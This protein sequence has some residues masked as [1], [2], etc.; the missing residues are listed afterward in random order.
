MRSLLSILT[1][2]AFAAM[3]LMGMTPEARRSYLQFEQRAESGDAEAMYRLGTILERGWDS[4][5]PDT[6][7]ALKM[8]RA[9]A[10]AGFPP[11]MNYMGYLYGEGFGDPAVTGI[12]ADR[13]SAEMWLR[14]SADAGDPRAM[15]NLAYLLLNYADSTAKKCD[16]TEVFHRRDS[17]AAIYLERASALGA[18]TASS[19][20]GD[21]YREGRGVAVDT[22]R[23]VALYESAMRSGLRDAEMRL[24]SMMGRKWERL[25]RDSAFNLGLGYYSTFAPTAGTILI[26]QCALLP[27]I[28]VD[29]LST[30]TVC[31][32]LSLAARAMTLT[33]D[34]YSRGYGRRYNHDK[35]MEWYA[36]GALGGDPSA[37]FIIAETLEVFPD[38]LKDMWDELA[39]YADEIGK[40]EQARHT[41]AT[42]SGRC[43]TGVL[44]LDDLKD[45]ELLKRLAARK[46]VN[47]AVSANRALFA[48]S[49]H[50]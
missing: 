2:V 22:L 37:M 19:M 1:G 4:I 44:T 13:D 26:E 5:A 17:L 41:F 20:L 10:E 6:L 7:R 18:P 40:I 27:G 16:E 36:K 11:A 32:S 39:N 50:R 24:I 14:R 33:G 12:R 48:T 28:P 45:V 25:D 9:S 35:S 38:A 23:A 46:G 42:G 3:T 15:S 43:G 47:D 49:G 21:L 8:F 34:A 29:S 30:A 31:D